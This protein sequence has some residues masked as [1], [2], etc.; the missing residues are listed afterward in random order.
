MKYR[1]AAEALN[2]STI[3][4]AYMGEPDRTF[5]LSRGLM[6]NSALNEAMQEDNVDREMTRNIPTGQR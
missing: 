4:L 2:C 5:W 1:A 6:W 3:D